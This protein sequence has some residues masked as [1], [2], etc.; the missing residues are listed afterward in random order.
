MSIGGLASPAKPWEW[1]IHCASHRPPGWPQHCSV[2]QICSPKESDLT[3]RFAPELFKQKPCVL[4]RAPCDFGTRLPALR[5]PVSP[6]LANKSA[7]FKAKVITNGTAQ[8][9]PRPCSCLMK[10]WWSQAGIHDATHTKWR[11]TH[12]LMCTHKM[13]R[14][15]CS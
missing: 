9:T 7:N 8:K 3:G 6:G 15:H 11:H 13:K 12:C 10:V 14:V 4:E 2:L 1:I 5:F